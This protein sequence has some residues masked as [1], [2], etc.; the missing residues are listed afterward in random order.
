MKASAQSPESHSVRLF[1]QALLK[2]ILTIAIPVTLQTILF[3]SK[4]LV[5]LIMVGQLSEHDIAAV[6]VAGRALFVAIILLS[7]VTTGG[8]MLAAQYFG[9][10]DNFGVTRSVALTWI[11]ASLAALIPVLGFWLFGANIVGLSSQLDVVQSLGHDYLQIAGL[12]LFCVAFSGSVAAGLRSM[13][14]ASVSTWLSGIGIVLNIFFNWVFIFG[15]LGAP[16]LG[17]KG[18]ALATV[19]SSVIEVTL[20][21]LYLQV[22]KHSLRFNRSVIREAMRLKH[23]AQFV[24]LAIPTTTNFLLWAGG[25]FTYTAIMGKSSDLGLVVLAVMTPIEAFSLSFLVGIANASSVIVGN[26]LGANNPNLAYKHAMGFTLLAFIVTVIVAITLYLSKAWVLGMFTALSEEARALADTFYTIV[27]FGIVL[28]S[29][30]TTMVVGVLRAGGDV[31][32]CLYQ[33]LFTQWGF[34]IPLAA[35]GGLIL[36]LAPEWVF[37]MFFLET[38]FKWFA[39]IHRFR[40]RKWINSLVND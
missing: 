38:L 6:G 18:A 7:G 27:C 13:H 2:S 36:G 15:R 10:K 4:G 29:L 22:R 26:H 21:L 39:C 20:T 14:Q 1:D 24:R 33:D 25:L 23:V 17:L 11:M 37:A 16:E 30:P 19:I 28:R 32:F 34:G 8:A 40:S 3:S 9:A 35:I 5:D 31:K 12:S